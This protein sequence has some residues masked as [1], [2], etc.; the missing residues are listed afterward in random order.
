MPNRFNTLIDSETKKEFNARL[1]KITEDA[2]DPRKKSALEKEFRASMD[3]KIGGKLELLKK[4]VEL[5]KRLK[6][7][8]EIVSFAYIAK[9]YFGKSRN[10]LYQRINGNTVNGKPVSLNQE[11]REVLAN[12]LQDISKKIGSI[13]VL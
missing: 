2:K 9:K 10:W 13:S 4:E 7:I 1:K 5:R 12:A 8:N 3:E 11:Q 6:D